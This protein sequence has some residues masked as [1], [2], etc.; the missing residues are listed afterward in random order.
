MKP[1]SML[2]IRVYPEVRLVNDATK[3]FASWLARF[4]MTPADRARV[5]VVE[6]EEDDPL[7]ALFT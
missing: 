3:R 5:S 4:G 2:M 1:P 7:D 6:R